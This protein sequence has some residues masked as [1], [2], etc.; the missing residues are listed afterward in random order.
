[1]TDSDHRGARGGSEA[2]AGSIPGVL[3]YYLRVRFLHIPW[4]YDIGS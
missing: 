3:I 2:Y 1:M 4:E